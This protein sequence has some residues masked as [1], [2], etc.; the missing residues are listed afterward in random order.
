MLRSGNLLISLML[1]G[2]LISTVGC[3]S[4]NPTELV[5]LVSSPTLTA[6]T[7]TT[8]PSRTVPTMTTE[9]IIT[10]TPDV[11]IEYSL[12]IPIGNPPVIDGIH[13]PGEWDD[14]AVETLAD[15]SQILILQSGD[16][17]YLGIKRKDESLFANNVFINNGDEIVILHSS[18]ALGTASYQKEGKVW[19]QTQ[20]FVWRCRKTDNSEAA[21]GERAEFLQGEGWLASNGRMGTPN[22]MEYQIRKPDQDF[23]FA[24]TIIAATFPYE[25]TPWPVNLND[26]SMKDFPGGLPKIMEFTP[27]E[28]GILQFG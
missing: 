17:I 12:S 7:L 9:P 28:W 11:E 24:M 2:I 1:A 5:P 20:D 10:T 14:A 3:G 15:G 25:K 27:L 19:N 4:S 16:F 26:D 6:L 22:E 21:Q 23:R 8:V 18:A 13:S